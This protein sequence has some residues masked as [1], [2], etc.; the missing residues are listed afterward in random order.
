MNPPF[1]DLE[2]NRF[3]AAKAFAQE[4]SELEWQY[5]CSSQWFLTRVGLALETGDFFSL[6]RKAEE[7]LVDDKIRSVT[8]RSKDLSH[9]AVCVD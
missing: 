6:Q 7:T 3:R 9:S 8:K 2:E 1:V 5:L 4:F